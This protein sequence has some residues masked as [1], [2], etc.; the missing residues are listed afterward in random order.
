M[1]PGIVRIEKTMT[2]NWMCLGARAPYWT[3]SPWRALGQAF[4]R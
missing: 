1:A 3:G 4:Q 2:Q